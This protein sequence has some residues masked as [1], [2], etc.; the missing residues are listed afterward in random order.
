MTY[1]EPTP[2]EPTLRDFECGIGRYRVCIADTVEGCQA[3][4]VCP[5]VVSYRAQ[6]AMISNVP[7]LQMKH[8]EPTPG[9]RIVEAL[10]SLAIAVLLIGLVLVGAWLA[11]GSGP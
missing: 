8:R 5:F 10:A 6:I 7:P 9:E 4:D 3:I 1:R 11:K 2:K